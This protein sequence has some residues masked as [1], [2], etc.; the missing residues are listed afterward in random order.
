MGR[1]LLAGLA[2]TALDEWLVSAQTRPLT[3]HTVSSKPA[4]RAEILKVRAQGHAVVVQ[5]LELGLCSAAVPLR[6][7][8]A[9]VV[10]ALNVGLPFRKG[11]KERL[12]REILPA[13][14]DAQRGIEEAIAPLRTLS[15]S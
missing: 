2:N 9:R 13:L 6:D 8:T 11:V 7:R 1:V 10:A 5:E 12:S 3:P 4:L 14:R 15:G